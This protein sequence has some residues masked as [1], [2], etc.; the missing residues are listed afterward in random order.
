MQP[1]QIWHTANKTCNHQPLGGIM[2]GPHRTIHPQG[3]GQDT[4]WLYVRHND[5]PSNQL[6]WDCWVAISQQELDIPTGTKGQKGKD[7]H[8]QSQ[9]PYF[10]KT[11]ATVGRL[12]NKTWFSHYPLS[13][14]IIYD[15]GSEFKLHFKT[16]CE[17]YGLKHKPTSVKNPQGNAILE[18]VHQTIMAMLCTAELDMAETVSKSDIADFSQ[19]PHGPFA[20]PIIQY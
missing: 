10:D 18:Q 12:V 19:M 3:Q 13:Q 5:R 17:S 16:L 8:I 7:K 6:V 1:T 15:N 9:Q 14:Y 2:C 4:N 11:S 20:L